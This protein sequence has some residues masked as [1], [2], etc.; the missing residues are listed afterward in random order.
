MGEVY[1]ARDT[2]L[3]REVAIKV[4]PAALAQDS[5]RMARFRREAQ[6][7][8][9]LNHP[10]IASLYGL[11][12]SCQPGALVM[13]LVEGRTLAE[14]IAAGPMAPAEALPVAKQIAAAIE[15]A[16]ERG[17]HHRDLKPA[18]VKITPEGAVKVLDFGLAKAADE[19]AAS[20]GPETSPTLTQAPMGGGMILG[21]AA[22]MSP[23]Q[24]SGQPVD[25]RCDIWSFGVVLWEMLCGRR[26]FEGETGAHTLAAVLRGEANLERL[27]AATPPAIRELLRRCLE[28]DVKQRL[29]DIG[30]ARIT[31]QECLDHPR[32][33]PG[34]AAAPAAGALPW[35]RRPVVPWTV[36]AA[37]VLL[38]VLAA[39]HFRERA[40][41][42]HPVQCLVPPPEKFFSQWY[43]MPVVAPDGRSVILNAGDASASMLH[44]R[45]L[46]SSEARPLPGTES[47]YFPFWSPDSRSI[48]FFTPGK[49]NKID[50][51]GG[52]PLVLCDVP[53]GI[54]M[55]GTW[56]REGVIVFA[57]GTGIMF[58]V[59]AAGGE[60]KPVLP[61]D[62]SRQETA[63]NWPYFLPDGKHFLYL[64]RSPEAG[65]SGVY[66]AALDSKITKLV[67]SGE[68]NA[69]YASPGYLLFT[70]QETLFAQ[71]FDA[72]K[73]ALEGVPVPI[74]QGVGRIPGPEPGS[75]YSASNNGV[76]A[77]RAG[78]SVNRRLVWYERG[79]KRLGTAGEPGPYHQ[80][81]PSPDESRLAVI[82]QAVGGVA[83]DIWLLE[84]RSGIFSRFTFSPSNEHDLVWSPDSREIVFN[85]DRNGGLDLYRKPAGGGEEER[86]LEDSGS[87]F[88]EDWLKDG[89]IVYLG[90][91]GETIYR[92]P[93]AGERKP[94]PVFHSE[95]PKDEVHVSPDQRW[96]AYS[97]HESG[98]WEIYVAPF[99]K[100][101]GRRQISTGGGCQPVWRKD[102]RELFFLSLDGKMM[103]VDVKAGASFETGPPKILF[104]ARL[105]PVP[106]QGQYAATADGRK[107][108]V[109]EPVE[110]AEPTEIVLNWTAKL[111][112]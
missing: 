39:I 61:L 41:D 62:Q 51:A 78:R 74:A 32:G 8:A 12:D 33:R 63:H 90:P 42:A 111:T 72:G 70:H 81:A 108:I 35:V 20:G 85:S 43:D 48:A 4:L 16:H 65:R 14:R 82:R 29:R 102:G 110:E 26:L 15:A 55:G 22:Y 27:P 37:A 2:R 88:P 89:S 53:R 91:R 30:E 64:A 18:N 40:P 5:G 3:G 67:V 104:E 56:S 31:I 83:W 103:S 107:F 38:A 112:R 69:S 9:S 94:Q 59:P 96:V 54:A 93:L 101:T 71:P 92:L 98:R 109:A 106:S 44:I 28:K 75:L 10:N 50:L 36:A 46:D 47:A 34:A 57:A 68:T 17:I 86:L 7:L 6:L 21:T 25:K 45:R 1:R 73:L 66:A 87:I 24:A 52:P 99:P 100:F 97:S 95:F 58:R 19:G 23:E 49:L 11:E 60:P 77:Y 13:E 79:G 76:L 105:Q 80:F 84:L